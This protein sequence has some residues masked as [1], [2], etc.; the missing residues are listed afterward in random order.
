MQEV[1]KVARRSGIVTMT[2]DF[3]SRDAY[4]G[5]MKG[6][7]CSI[8]P[9]VRIIDITH[10]IRPQ[11]VLEAAMLLEAAYPWFPAGTVH[12]VVVDPGVGSKRM[13]L[14]L[15]SDGQVFV[16]PNN[17]VLSAPLS[18]RVVVAH[19]IAEA[20]YEMPNRSDT[21]HGRDV[22]A[23]AAG[24]LAA[25][26]TVDFLGPAV[27]KPVILDLPKP[28]IEEGR[29]L[30]EILRIDRFGNALSSIPRVVLQDLAG[31][32]YEVFVS[33]KSYGPLRQRYDQVAE[34]EALA[35]TGGDGR[36]EIA[37]NGGSAHEAL[38]IE[39]GEPMEIR[40]AAGG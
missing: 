11:K 14:A 38:G 29:V 22:F 5:A 7:I 24:H 8:F 13:P 6:V 35:L 23:P 19:E 16:G 10:E 34:G 37:V 20:A 12:V 17:G 9:G 40:P 30:G 21:F 4:V 1:P 25:G 3:G 31:P 39:A 15:A 27:E 26:L 36:I 28:T 32:P 18:G 2:T 33:G